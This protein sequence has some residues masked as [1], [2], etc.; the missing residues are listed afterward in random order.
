MRKSV[1]KL[2]TGNAEQDLMLR[3]SLG[4]HHVGRSVLALPAT[5]QDLEDL[6]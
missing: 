2:T 1:T 5:V 4:L 6:Y 3:S